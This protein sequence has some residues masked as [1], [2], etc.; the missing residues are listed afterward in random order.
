MRSSGPVYLGPA[1]PLLRVSPSC[2]QGG[3]RTWISSGP[4][5][6]FQAYEAVGTIPF[7]AVVEVLAVF[8]FKASRR[9]SLILLGQTHPENLPFD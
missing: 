7:L 5:L 1:Y 9:D 8:F 2:N 4:G 3:T 6:L